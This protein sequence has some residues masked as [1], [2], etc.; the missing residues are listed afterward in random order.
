MTTITMTLSSPD[1]V[2][3]DGKGS[4]TASVTNGSTEAERVVLGAF[5]GQVTNPPSKT[6]ATI[7]NPLRTI[8]AGATEQYVVNFDTAGASAGSYPVKL[9]A[10]SA[11]DAP[12]DYADQA[13]VVTLTVPAAEKPKPP[14]PFPW[15]WVI[16]GGVVLL[17]VVGLILFFIF[18]DA[19]VPDVKTKPQAEAVQIITRAGFTATTTQTEST[20][21]EGTVVNQTPAG[22]E[23]VG[24]GSTVNLEIAVPVQATVPSV[25]G[26]RIENARTAF[27]AAQIQLDFRQGSTC[28]ASPA[29]SLQRCVVL[30]VIPQAGERVR[31]NTVVFVRTELRSSIVVDPGICVTS[32][33]LCD[34]L[35]Q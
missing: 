6:Y 4:L 16:I 22:G 11:D 34:T 3:K 12:E 5:P 25:V 2:L 10:Y 9:I 19:N 7:P 32:P 24:R 20:E 33:R 15:L 31:V 1:V 29:L 26:L 14:R 35:T 23:K 30:E 28:Q 17:A 13:H 21:A 18:K 27:Q 8:A